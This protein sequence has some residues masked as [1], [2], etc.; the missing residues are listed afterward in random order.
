[1][2][3]R[4]GFRKT[5]GWGGFGAASRDVGVEWFGAE[6]GGG[7]M[8]T[9]IVGRIRSGLTKVHHEGETERSFREGETEGVEKRSWVRDDFR[10]GKKRT[11]RRERA[12]REGRER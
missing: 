6:H 1:M 11:E 2:Q 9:Q 8:K 10:R 5:W 4:G 12:E 3:I 7:W